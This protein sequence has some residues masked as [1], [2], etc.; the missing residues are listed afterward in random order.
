MNTLPRVKPRR[1]GNF[2][3]EEKR[4][5]TGLAAKLT[6]DPHKRNIPKPKVEGV[7]E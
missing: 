6:P 1:I 7:C 4:G 2:A 3:P 5:G